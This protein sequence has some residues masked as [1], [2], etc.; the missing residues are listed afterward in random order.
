MKWLQRLCFWT[1][2]KLGCHVLEQTTAK[3]HAVNT[4]TF[5]EKFLK[6][7]YCTRDVFFHEPKTV[8]IGAEDFDQLMS[9]KVGTL[10][11]FRASYMYDGTIMGM[12]VNIVPWMQGVLII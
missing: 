4:D 5:S 1:L 9:V 3:V 2:G 12:Q 7:Y 11:G 6:Q 10:V 8:F